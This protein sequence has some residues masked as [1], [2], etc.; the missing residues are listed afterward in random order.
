MNRFKFWF[1]IVALL[2]VIGGIGLFVYLSHKS[3]IEQ[4]K[5]LE[6]FKVEQKERAKNF[7]L[8]MDDLAAKKLIPDANIFK[9]EFQ[10]YY[11][12][13][14]HTDIVSLATSTYNRNPTTGLR[15]MEE[16]CIAFEANA[17]MSEW[18]AGEINTLLFKD[19]DKFTEGLSLLDDSKFTCLLRHIDLSWTEDSQNE[20]FDSEVENKKLAEHLR[21]G[22]FK[23][24]VNV[25]KLIEALEGD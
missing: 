2:F 9:S 12:E 15:V 7:S 1:N 16:L 11:S 13:N 17:E 25:K 10:R 5:S 3:E 24:N 20:G 22:K 19:K 4:K 23:D 21:S 6:A 14:G 8:A 18:I